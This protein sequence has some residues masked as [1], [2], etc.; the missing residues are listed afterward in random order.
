[1]PSRMVARGLAVLAAL[2]LLTACATGE[3]GE[4]PQVDER[5]ETPSSPRPT[6][7]P[8]KVL[9]DE[10]FDSGRLDRSVF[11][12]CHWWA[13]GG[14]T[15]AS[16]DELEWYVPEQVTVADGELRLTAAEEAVRGTDGRPYDFRSGMVTTGPPPR[17]EEAPAKL[18]FTYGSVEARVKTP[19]GQGLWPAFWLL[20]A[21]RESR[22]EIDVLEVLGDDPGELVMHLHPRDRG[23]ESPSRSYRVPGP[24]FAEAWHTIRLDWTPKKLE[25]FV[26]D[27]RVWRVT[28][29]QVPDEPMY[30]VL[31]LA[32]GGVYPGPPDEN[33]KFPAT[34]AI[35]YLKITA[36]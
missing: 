2:T 10:S 21:D 14:C 5:I 27:V 18:A 29:K 30:V 31:N 28:G 11:N 8:D 17:D 36:A 1:M 3:I 4:A 9:L 25:F 13:D 35:D 12:T 34:F 26:D 7:S 19:A 22:P 24:N 6:P 33:T 16:N 32:V 15:I 23:A 20:P